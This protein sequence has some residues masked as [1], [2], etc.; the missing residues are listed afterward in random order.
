VNHVAVYEATNYLS[1]CVC[2]TDVGQELVAQTFTNRC[3]THDTGDVNERHRSRQ[4]T[5]RSIHVGET[6]QARV[7]KVDD[8]DVRFDSCERVV[9]RQNVVLG[10]CIKE[11]RLANIWQSHDS[12]S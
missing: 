5:L 1:D 7:W 3:A 4:Q 6:L 9:R 10:Q 11:G 12:D 8:T 2:F